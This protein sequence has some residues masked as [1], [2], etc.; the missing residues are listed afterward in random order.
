MV[1][2]LFDTSLAILFVAI[3]P[4]MEEANT[5]GHVAFLLGKLGKPSAAPYKVR[6]DGPAGS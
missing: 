4:K 6:L 2:K 5:S 3:L 1:V